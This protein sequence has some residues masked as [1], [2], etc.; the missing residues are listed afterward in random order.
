[1]G[2]Y[3]TNYNATPYNS[4]R[5]PSEGSSR[6]F[7]RVLDIILDETH[8]EYYLRGGAKAINGVFFRYQANAITVAPA[9]NRTFASQN[10]PQANLHL[11]RL[12]QNTTLRL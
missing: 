6:T 8:P 10:Q 11:H 1:M 2:Q 3:S 5:S 9:D 12:K 7:G 4:K